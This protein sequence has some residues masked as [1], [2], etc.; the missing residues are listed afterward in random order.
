MLNWE[1]IKTPYQNISRENYAYKNIVIDRIL[2][3][4]IENNLDHRL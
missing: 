3:E 2:G 4:Q 1:L